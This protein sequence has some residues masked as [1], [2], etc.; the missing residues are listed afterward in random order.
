VSE[1][2]NPSTGVTGLL[3]TLAFLFI[4]VITGHRMC[5][6]SCVSAT[7]FLSRCRR[8][9]G[10]KPTRTVPSVLWSRGR[11]RI[12]NAGPRRRFLLWSLRVQHLAAD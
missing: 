11:Q 12:W 2:P 3:P 9:L 8:W 5:G 1:I 10:T 6:G 7:A 4:P